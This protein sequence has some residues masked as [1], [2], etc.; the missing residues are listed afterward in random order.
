MVVY[1]FW[2][3]SGALSGLIVT[4]LLRVIEGLFF[5]RVDP[6]QLRAI[7][8]FGVYILGAIWFMFII[9]SET[10][11]RKY[12][13]PDKQLSSLLKIV[14]LEAIILALIYGANLIIN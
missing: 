3:V 9:G 11:F 5:L 4:F 7:S 8:R 14:A 12:L 1:T 13:D 10:Y 2:I 6:W